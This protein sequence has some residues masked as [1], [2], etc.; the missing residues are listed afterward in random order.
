MTVIP[1]PT[2]APH[3]PG[4]TTDKA[5]SS[6]T[7]GSDFLSER[8][9]VACSSSHTPNRQKR[10]LFLYYFWEWAGPGQVPVRDLGRVGIGRRPV[11]VRYGHPAWQW[12]EAVPQPEEQRKDKVFWKK[13]AGLH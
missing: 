3:C 6:S 7:L 2:A 10:M 1:L 5:E 11:A 8:S 9:K 4:H 13:P 12:L